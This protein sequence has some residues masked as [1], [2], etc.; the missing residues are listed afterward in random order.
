MHKQGMDFTMGFFGTTGFTSSMTSFSLLTLI[1]NFSPL[2]AADY[3]T[4]GG[5]DWQLS[6]HIKLE[7]IR[8]AGFAAAAGLAVV[9]DTVVAVL[10][11]AAG[12]ASGITDFGLWGDASTAG[13]LPRQMRDAS[14]A[15]ADSLAWVISGR[16]RL[17]VLPAR[18]SP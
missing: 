1:S 15:A 11:G 3:A 9:E 10:T 16:N 7:E 18:W 12:T 14:S 8:W 5:G 13:W 2:S 6:L 4:G 17:P